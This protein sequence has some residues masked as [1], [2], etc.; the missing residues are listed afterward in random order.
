MPRFHV[1]MGSIVHSV[2]AASYQIKDGFVTFK[3]NDDVPI[4]SFATIHVRKVELQGAVTDAADPY[5]PQVPVPGPGEWT[6]PG[7]EWE[8]PALP[9]EI[10]LE[11]SF[12]SEI[13]PVEAQSWERWTDVWRSAPGSASPPALPSLLPDERAGGLGFDDSRMSTPLQAPVED[14][15]PPAFSPASPASASS[16]SEEREDAGPADAVAEDWSNARDANAADT[17]EWWI[18]DNPPVP[19]ADPHQWWIVEDSAEATTGTRTPA[20]SPED[21]AS[22]SE[23]SRPTAE[24]EEED[25]SRRAGRRPRD[26]RGRDSQHGWASSLTSKRNRAGGSGSADKGASLSHQLRARRV[27]A[28]EE[29]DTVLGEAEVLPPAPAQEGTGNVVRLPVENHAEAVAEDVAP[30]ARAQENPV[31]VIASG[32]RAGPKAVGSERVAH[33]GA[34]SEAARPESMAAGSAAAERVVQEEAAPEGSS[35]AVGP[36]E[37]AAAGQENISPDIKDLLEMAAVQA[38]VDAIVDAAVR[39]SSTGLDDEFE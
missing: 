20:P 15:Q 10:T 16:A 14:R 26:R 29:T 38:A 12:S 6:T 23:A 4:A 17:G 13:Q 36:E 30:E 27:W 34:A 22:G 31:T 32:G 8:R 11:S 9:S 21:E 35:G 7:F 39:G 3:N 5:S 18:V 37:S 24:P 19:D 25:A 28:M 2:D 33:R 1:D